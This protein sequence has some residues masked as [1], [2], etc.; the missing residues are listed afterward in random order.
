[1]PGA[2][3]MIRL[4]TRAVLAMRE[5]ITFL[6][7][8]SELS[9]GALREGSRP[10]RSRRAPGITG[11]VGVC[12]QLSASETLVTAPGSAAQCGRVAQTRLAK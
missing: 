11:C 3:L 6:P 5:P 12:G 2:F 4:E 8:V 7:Q 10:G 9:F 1:M